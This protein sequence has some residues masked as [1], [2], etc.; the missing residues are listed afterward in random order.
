M[1][2]GDDVRWLPREKAAGLLV[3]SNDFWLTDR[4]SGRRHRPRPPADSPVQQARKA[5]ADELRELLKRSGA[6]KAEPARRAG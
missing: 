4:A 1:E 5:L 2:A 3:P 6:S